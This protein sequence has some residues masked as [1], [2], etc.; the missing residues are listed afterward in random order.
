LRGWLAGFHTGA[1]IF[2]DI[3]PG[4]ANRALEHGHRGLVFIDLDAVDR[5]DGSHGS[6]R[7]RDDDVFE[8]GGPFW[9]AEVDPPGL[10]SED[11]S[12]SPGFRFGQLDA[13]I[14]RDR[15]GC[16]LVD[17]RHDSRLL[18]CPEG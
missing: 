16:C 11:L 14:L 3:S 7:S 4:D 13:G 12:P 9:A 10:Y 17:E 6:M 2:E 15:G 8:G 18:A 5:P 1:V